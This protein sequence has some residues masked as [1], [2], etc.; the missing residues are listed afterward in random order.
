VAPT[1]TA[2]RR[3]RTALVAAQPEWLLVGA[4][5]GDAIIHKVMFELQRT[6]PQAR[7]AF[8]GVLDDFGRCERWVRGGARCYLSESSPNERI[9][10][11]LQLADELDTVVIDACFQ[12]AFLE[13]AWRFKPSEPLTSRELEIL[14]LAREGLHTPEIAHRL[15]LTEHTIAFHF[16]NSIAKLGVTGRTQAVARAILVGLIASA[17][18]SV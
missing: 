9:V 2:G 4:E 12:R 6:R 7:V 13:R 5:I 11:A 8:L 14:R 16:R 3:F 1:E 17:E 18:P 15:H 10:E